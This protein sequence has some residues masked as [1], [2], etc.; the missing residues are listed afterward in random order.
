MITKDRLMD[1]INRL[2]SEKESDVPIDK[3]AEH[4]ELLRAVEMLDSM[5]ELH[6]NVD[7]EEEAILRFET[8]GIRRNYSQEQRDLIKFMSLLDDRLEQY[9]SRRELK[10]SD[11]VIE[12]LDTAIELLY[13]FKHE[14]KQGK[15]P[16]IGNLILASS[17][18]NQLRDSFLT[19]ENAKNYG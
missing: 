13:V 15:G 10:T 6:T 5:F 4:K 19:E 11:N 8:T 12:Q 3:R 9:F 16:N 17:I 18:I 2:K 7:T 1:N 14:I